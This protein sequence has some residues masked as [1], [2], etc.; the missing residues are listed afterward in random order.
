MTKKN[1]NEIPKRLTPKSST[2]N[3]LLS[4]SGNQCAY[5]NCEEL[6]FNDENRLIA[7]CC[8]IE[9]AM[10]GGERF[11][12]NQT[13]E[14]RR[15]YSNLIF[16]CHK[17]H[18]ETDNT[19][20]YTVELL[21]EIKENHHIRFS[22][23]PLKIKTRLIESVIERF[24]D[25]VPQ[26][27]ETI[28]RIEDKQDS[29]IDLLNRPIGSDSQ[30]KINAYYGQPATL[31]FIGR[32]EEL[33]AVNKNFD[34]Y[35]T[36]IVEG[37]SG[38]GK[39][40]LIAHL[41]A[42]IKSH[43]ILWIDCEIINSKALFFNHISNFLK[44]NFND[45]SLEKKLLS[46]DNL[47]ENYLS[48]ALNTYSIC[49]VFDAL[50]S[51]KHQLLPLIK[52]LNNEIASSKILISTTY[53]FSIMDFGNPF[54]KLQLK[55]LKFDDFKSLC[56]FYNITQINENEIR[57]LHK[58]LGA[59]PY[60]LKLSA[61]II[62]YQ[63]IANFLSSLKNRGIGE[64][65][66]FIKNKI[67]SKLVEN[68]IELIS[69][70]IVLDIP[71]RYELSKYSTSFTA[72][73]TSLQQKFL[74]ERTLDDFFIIPEYIKLYLTK[75]IRINE[76]E[77]IKEN[78]IKYLKS[79]NEDS[80]FFEINA[81]VHLLLN[82]ERETE[83]KTI[84][85]NFMSSLM[86]QGFFYLVLEYGDRL[87]SKDFK[88][89]WDFL[90]YIL[91]R[92]HRMQGE[93]KK[94]LKMYDLGLKLFSDSSLKSP[95]LFEKASILTYLS[96]D[97]LDD[98][99]QNE[100]VSIY[101]EL[102]HSESPTIFVKS[103][104]ALFR[105][106]V[107]NNKEKQALNELLEFRDSISNLELQIYDSAQIY[108]SI[109]DVYRANSM[110]KKAFEAFDTSIDYYREAIDLHGMNMFEG[111]YHLY[112]SYGQTYSEAKDYESAAKMFGINVQLA[113]QFKMD[114]KLE[115]AILDFGYHLLLSENFEQSIIVLEEYYNLKLDN[116]TLDIDELPFI[117][118]CLLF[119]NWYGNDNKLQAI[120][121]LGHYM[122]SSL[123]NNRPPDVF[124]VELTRET[125]AI[126]KIE[127]FVKGMILLI[128]PKENKMEDFKKW[129]SKVANEKPELS[130]VLNSFLTQIK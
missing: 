60:L 4:R 85:S 57:Y 11:N 55:G 17:H 56:E 118:R 35:N 121:L 51:E 44:D 61:S 54:F 82:M 69:Y 128:L 116:Q 125:S 43:K 18:V 84:C 75:N 120:E 79:I 31:N 89:K 9:A 40:S 95:F 88:V 81:L 130:E 103:K 42:E 46:G 122:L 110:H 74:I 71:F 100:A 67:V 119:S 28:N 34:N 123:A 37:L 32:K 126:D 38:I 62:D 80:K 1:D 52:I 112:I 8:H 33:K 129:I 14:E 91:G 15:G 50:N 45:I 49:I 59:H 78:L 39:S 25:F 27:N 41:I 111:L 83:A 102:S 3:L 10:P 104:I 36:I 58:L 24:N 109:G 47:I 20:E 70:L 65:E 97:E 86:G 21:R 72:A 76:D 6:L 113:K 93:Y 99:K 90:Y 106:L 22:E 117:F 92:V 94:S 105:I 7:Q 127:Y 68:E 13:N 87:L 16:F 73:I 108:H 12:K 2:L 114:V 115:A 30:H 53:G 98:T 19:D 29:I 23:K 96:N 64:I 77:K 107:I 124:L 48:Q 101:K 66:V 26:L 5:P 63:P